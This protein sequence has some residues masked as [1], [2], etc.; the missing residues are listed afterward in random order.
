MT[1]TPPD[2]AGRAIDLL[3][4]GIDNMALLPRLGAASQV[5]IWVDDPDSVSDEIRTECARYSAPIGAVAQWVQEIPGTNRLVVRSPGFPRYRQDIASALT[6]TPPGSVTTAINMWLATFGDRYPTVVVTGT[7]GKSTVARMLASLLPGSELVGNIGTPI[8]S[9][10]LPPEGT[11]I[12]CE[13]SSYQAVDLTH[14]C[15]LAILTSLSEDHISWHGSVE[16]YHADKLAPVL[17]S[18]RALTIESLEQ[19]LSGHPDL[20]S[21][22][23]GASADRLSAL[24]SHMASNARLAIAAARRLEKDFGSTVVEDPE[25]TLLDLP[26][27]IGRLREISSTADNHRWFDDSL[28]S[29][30]SGAAAAVGAFS[31]DD[32]WLI[33]GGLDRNVSPQ[34][35]IDAVQACTGTISTI[36]VPD[37]GPDLVDQLAAAGIAMTHRLDAADVTQA[38]AL[39]RG[40][41]SAPSTVL[42]SPG[43]PTPPQH[44]NWANRSAAFEAAVLEN[45][46]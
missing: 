37:N 46:S 40:S 30:P 20:Q 36:A 13:V 8:W 18:S 21:I 35:L 11:V 22:P 45:P 24:P 44:G 16:R 23:A 33:L 29:N 41:A 14:R 10:S 25:G 1:I 3:G 4:A 2:V 19:L 38:V 9:I 26:A 28:A 5:R 6:N 12:V 43:A 15:D 27:M 7:K 31:G 32:L 17:D 39:V 42:F 34:P